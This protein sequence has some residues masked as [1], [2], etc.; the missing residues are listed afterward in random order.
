MTA[1]G[2][3]AVLTSRV[4]V[5]EKLL[6]HELDRRGVPYEV[7]DTRT[8]TFRLEGPDGPRL[9]FRGALAREVSHHRAHYAARLL[10]HSGV[11]VVNGAE[12]IALCGD[13]L[14]TTL[15]LRAAGLP[16]PRT[17]VALTPQAALD[18]LPD[19][20]LPA[21]VKPLVGS[22]GRLA[23]RLND[24]DAAQAVLEHRAAL[25]GAQ[26]HITYV[27][28]YV[29]KPGRDIRGLVAG[30]EILGAV[31]RTSAHWR[32]NTAAG[33]GTSPCP[34]DDD[35]AKLLLATSAALGPGVYGIDVV[36]DADGGLY[37]LEVNHTPEFH[38]ATGVLGLDLVGRYVDYALERLER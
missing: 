31:Y 4:R 28:E 32:T 14:L 6:L 23:A 22:W 8:A 29:A 36:E 10:E 26:Q 15:A 21:V 37:V 18:D 16:T 35:L 34:V 13:K 2:P 11:P 19:F 25:P 27:Q 12:V 7:I 1:A 3:L 24:G 5:E 38:G 30:D 17:L 9:P 33:A 20:G